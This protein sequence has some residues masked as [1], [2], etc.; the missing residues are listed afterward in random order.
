M[1]GAAGLRK[2]LE[3]AD[4]DLI[5]DPFQAQY[6]VVGSAFDGSGKISEET[7]AAH[8][9]RVTGIIS[10]Q[11]AVYRDESGSDLSGQRRALFPELARSSER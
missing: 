1:V 3:L 10:R 7:A 2:E 5:D 11:S 4:L 9:R 8:Y 6:V